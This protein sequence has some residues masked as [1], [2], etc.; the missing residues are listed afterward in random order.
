ML[1][2]VSKSLTA[3]QD[4]CGTHEL[5]RQSCEVETHLDEMQIRLPAQVAGQTALQCVGRMHRQVSRLLLAT[6]LQ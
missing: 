6:Q 4:V 3:L 1:H 2:S 5:G